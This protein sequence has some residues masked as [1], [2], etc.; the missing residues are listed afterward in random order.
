[1]KTVGIVGFGSFG[2]FLAEKLSKYFKISIY[3]H[4][5]KAPR[6]W[7]VGIK[8]VASCD[9]L[10]LSIPL[11]AY[12]QVL[13][14]LKPNL[15]KNT[16]IIDVCSVKQKP[17][18]IIKKMLPGYPL[19]AT[20]P[21][22]GP[23]SAAKT[24]RGHTLVICPADSK[25]KKTTY[26][27]KNFAKNKLG[28]N[29]VEV[30]AER[31]DKEMAKIH[32]LTFFIARVLKDYDLRSSILD[33]PSYKQLQ[34]MVELENRHSYDLFETIQSGNKYTKQIRTEFINAAIKLDTKINSDKIAKDS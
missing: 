16:V 17:L 9:Y 24:L 22:F 25:T 10:I 27:I 1:M 3:S 15:G 28:L 7:A 31:H 26:E 14:Q 29:V 5:G 21:L 12:Q 32:G 34:K 13:K 6:K 20:H 11:V 8:D 19:V 23:E 33:T 2:K 18:Q 4:S 30:S